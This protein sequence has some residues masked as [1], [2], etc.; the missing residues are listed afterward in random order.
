[1]QNIVRYRQEFL[2][3][4]TNSDVNYEMLER[5]HDELLFNIEFGDHLLT[6]DKHN[7]QELNKIFSDLAELA[8]YLVGVGDKPH[9]DNLHLQKYLKDAEN[10]ESKYNEYMQWL[11]KG[12]G[13]CLEVSRTYRCRF[14]GKMNVLQ[15]VLNHTRGNNHDYEPLFNDFISFIRAEYKKEDL[16]IKSSKSKDNKPFTLTEYY[17]EYK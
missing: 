1:M 13:D 14:T 2:K 11:S 3:R 9:I 6:R 7:A 8:I 12:Y 15:F 16:E 4:I 17:R 5:F 10:R